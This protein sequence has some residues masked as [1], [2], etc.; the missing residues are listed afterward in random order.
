MLRMSGHSKWATIKRRK[1]AADAERAKIFTKLIREVTIAA[2]IGGGSPDSNTRL[3]LAIDKARAQSVP[4]DRIDRAVLKGSGG[5]EGASLEEITYE[6]YGPGGVAILVETATDNKNRAVSEIRN[7]FTKKNG[8][9]G[10]SGS[11]AWMFEK[12][13]ILRLPDPSINEN[14]LIDKALTVGAEDVTTSD[15][16]YTITT[17]FS[18]FHHIK[19]LLEKQQLEFRNDSGIEMV[20]K[21]LVPVTDEDQ[22]KKLMALIEALEDLDDVQNVWANVD[23]ADAILEKLS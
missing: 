3:R 4:K 5:A 12:K 19:E 17:S 6:G 15:G 13:G 16:L 14:V 2:K 7:T 11:V 9:L 20:P 8:N 22:A 10:E 21:N 23:I 1:G 18:D